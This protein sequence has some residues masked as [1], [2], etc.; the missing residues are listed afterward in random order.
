VNLQKLNA[1]GVDAWSVALDG[2][3]VLAVAAGARIYCADGA[4][5]LPD[6]EGQELPAAWARIEV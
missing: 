1:A 3:L 5:F 2:Q 6:S 4:N